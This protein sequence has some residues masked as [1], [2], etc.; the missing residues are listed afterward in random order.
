MG[1]GQGDHV[2]TGYPL[3]FM[4]Y[5]YRRDTNWRDRRSAREV[6]HVVK[7]TG[8]T[9]AAPSPGKGHPR[10]LFRSHEYVCSCGH[11][12]WSCHSDIVRKPLMNP[13]EVP[14]EEKA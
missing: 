6:L 13:P 3:S 7:R 14:V 11:R 10:K 2:G 8:R 5:R 4:C 12:G 1:R 9:K